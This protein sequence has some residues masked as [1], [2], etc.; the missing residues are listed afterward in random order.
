MCNMHV[1]K[2]FS[3]TQVPISCRANQN[4]FLMRANSPELLYLSLLLSVY[5]RIDSIRLHVVIVYLIYDHCNLYQR[6]HSMQH[7]LLAR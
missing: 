2:R 7:P 4:V 5:R 1:S 3:I 6:A